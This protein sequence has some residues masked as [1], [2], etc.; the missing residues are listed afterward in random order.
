VLAAL[1]F[2]RKVS[3]TTTVSRV[4]KDYVADSHVHILEGKD[5][6]DYATVYRIHGP[7]LFGTTD[8]FAEILD[9]LDTLPPIVILR[10]RTMTAIDAT[11]LAAIRELA[12]TLHASGRALIL[13]GAR[14]QPA[15]LMRQAEFERHVGAENI[16]FSVT[17]AL[18]RAAEIRE[19]ETP[20]ARE[21]LPAASKT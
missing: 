3:N 11:G 2:I 15:E 1:T 9:E 8:K 12:D 18:Q 16:C 5:I 17:D 13:C 14:P 20:S 7:F 21:L 4:T 10:L 6:P 19:T